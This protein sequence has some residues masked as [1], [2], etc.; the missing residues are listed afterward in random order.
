MNQQYQDRLDDLTKLADDQRLAFT[1]TNGQKWLRFKDDYDV[2]DQTDISEA[3]PRDKVNGDYKKALDAG[4]QAFGSRDA[5]SAKLQSDVIAS[6]NQG[7]VWR[8]R[9]RIQSLA[10]AI[11]RCKALNTYRINSIF[12]VPISAMESV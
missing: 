1:A 4:D 2:T 8:H 11:G 10:C 9:T 3:F 5:Q 12:S 6:L 7:T